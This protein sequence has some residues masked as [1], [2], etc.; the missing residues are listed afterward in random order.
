M[1]ESGENT[2]MSSVLRAHFFCK[3]NKVSLG[4]QLTQPAV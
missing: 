3:F 4:T 2:R 1:S